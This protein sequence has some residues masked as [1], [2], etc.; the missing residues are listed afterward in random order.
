MTNLKKPWQWIQRHWLGLVVAYALV[1]GLTYTAI[2]QIAEPLNILDEFLDRMKQR[3]SIYLILIFLVS[4]HITLVLELIFRWRSW[5]S[6]R[7]TRQ[8]S[9]QSSAGKSPD[10]GLIHRIDFNYGDSPTK[11][12][13]RIGDESQF[14]FK[15]CSDGYLGGALEIESRRWEPID[16]HVS[17]V[18]PAAGL[19]TWIEYVTQLGEKA[20]I[21]A[22][23]S[24]QSQD[25]TKSKEAWLAFKV[26]R[27][28]AESSTSS[29]WCVYVEPVRREGPWLVFQIDLNDAVKQ[30]YGREGWKL[31]S[32]ECIRL[33]GSLSLA[34]I[35]IFE[36]RPEE[37]RHGTIR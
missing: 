14:A 36:S 3:A 18:N 2:W 19:G 35:S 37:R 28:P 20:V 29:E 30:T 22:K 23:I 5:S 21:Y 11:H 26:G 8:G 17:D 13:W 33:R 32:L 1:F 16:Y 24:I 27:R 7:I 15:P 34:H 31:G 4:A 6:Y 25:G 12:G 10:T 9:D